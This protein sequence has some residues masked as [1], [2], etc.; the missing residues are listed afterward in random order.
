MV[1]C[2]CGNPPPPVKIT[3]AYPGARPSV[4]EDTVCTPIMQQLLGIEGEA[5]VTCVS[6]AGHAEIFVQANRVVN[7]DVFTT[8][9]DNRV[10]LA[11]PVLPAKANVSHPEVVSSVT[12]PTARE[13]HDVEFPIIDIDREKA[14]QLGLSVS[15]AS[16]AVDKALGPG[17]PLPD[18]VKRIGELSVKSADGKDCLLTDFATIKTVREPNIRI[19]CE[20]PAGRA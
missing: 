8:L 13:I 16:D 17:E 18:A 1:L 19:R 12:I 11:E 4:M 9:V 5:T 15:A 6:S 20:P 3:V 10:R 14:L 7:G 2:G